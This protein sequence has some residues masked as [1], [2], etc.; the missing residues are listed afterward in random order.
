MDFHDRIEQLRAN[1]PVAWDDEVS[2]WVVTDYEL[3]VEC[4][5]DATRFTVD[6]PRFS[7]AQI[8]GP[9]ML[10]LDGDEHRRHR[11][12]F[13][14]MFGVAAM[15]RRDLSNRI[16]NLANELVTKLKSNPSRQIDLR[17]HIAG[18]FA[19]EVMRIA[20]GLEQ[21]TS[22]ALLGWYR[23]IVD[24]VTELSSGYV[25]EQVS[26]PYK[27]AMESLGS[28]VFD[29]FGFSAAELSDTELM[30]NVAVCLFGGIETAEGMITNSF[31]HLLQH[32]NGST[33][34]SDQARLLLALEESLRLEPSVTRVDRFSTEDVH[35][36]PALIRKGDMVILSIAGANRDPKKFS[37]PN[38]FIADRSNASAHVT[39]AQG[40]HACI[41]MH[42]AKHE[43]QTIIEATFR[44]LPD[45]ILDDAEGGPTGTLFRKWNK[46]LVRWE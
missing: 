27:V 23:D 3:V 5:R 11:T 7:T 42:L 41:A 2:A 38:R 34:A 14:G 37:Q 36:E 33:I 20:L 1:G 16:V 26:A 31:G 28:A 30:S 15:S 9:S 12:P 44:I 13:A 22:D 40:P 29:S 45:L 4:M 39:F 25:L 46:L 32:P 24:A 8:V 17:S 43:A 19:A 21:T 18:P 10:S 35:I 6:D